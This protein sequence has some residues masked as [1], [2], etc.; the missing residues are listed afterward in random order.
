M[1]SAELR[2]TIKRAEMILHPYIYLMHP[3]DYKQIPKDFPEYKYIL[4]NSGVQK[5]NVIYVDREEI[6]KW[7]FGM[8][9]DLE[10]NQC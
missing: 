9:L 2:A 10:K 4:T 6:E 7:T 5:G 8:S 1:T 3:D